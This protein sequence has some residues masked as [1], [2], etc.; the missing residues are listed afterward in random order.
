MLN[1]IVSPN[2]Q[3]KGKCHFWWWGGKNCIYLIFLLFL[4]LFPSIFALYPRICVTKPA[5]HN[6]QKTEKEYGTTFSPQTF[7]LILR[8]WNNHNMNLKIWFAENNF[9]LRIRGH[10]SMKGFFSMRRLFSFWRNCSKSSTRNIA[11][12]GRSKL[13]PAHNELFLFLRISN[14]LL[15]LINR[16]QIRSPVTAGSVR[17]VMGPFTLGI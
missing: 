3:P 17:S 7:F 6:T 4:S 8:I 14:Q 10:N 13:L 11:F 2:L 16:K 12:P 5:D 1:S 15:K 9:P